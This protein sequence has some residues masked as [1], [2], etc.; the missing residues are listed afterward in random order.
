MKKLLIIFLGLSLS[1]V[2]NSQT[3]SSKGILHFYVG[4]Y[5]E[6]NGS[7]GIYSFGLDP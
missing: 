2:A 5:T 1:G 6:E 4:T 3:P 7:E